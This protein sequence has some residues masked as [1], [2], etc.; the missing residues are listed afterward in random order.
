MNNYSY[1]G[2]SLG[3]HA[4]VSDPVS[5]NQTWEKV[6]TKNLGLDLGFLNNRLSFTGE[7]YTREVKGILGRGKSLPS[8]YG[9]DEP[10]VNANDLRTLGYELMLNWN[11][12]FILCSSPLNYSVGISFSDYT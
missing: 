12:S 11:E 2:T 5:G 1:D 8:I 4:T 6:I 3:N 9:A 7:V 10:Q